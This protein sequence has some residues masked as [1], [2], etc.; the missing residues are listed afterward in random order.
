MR[1]VARDDDEGMVAHIEHK[2]RLILTCINELRQ[3]AFH[4]KLRCGEFLSRRQG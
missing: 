2:E 4:C 1:I 3:G